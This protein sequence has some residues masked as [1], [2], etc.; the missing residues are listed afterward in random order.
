ARWPGDAQQPVSALD[1]Q[2]E[3]PM[4]YALSGLEGKV[5]VI[6]GAARM[7]SIGRSIAGRLAQ[8]GCDVVLT[9]TR[10]AASSFPDEE[11]AAGWT[12]IDAVVGEVEACGGRAPPPARGPAP[13]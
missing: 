10:R 4:P 12:G 7:R 1:E 3:A 9:G 6:T 2:L 13:P 8:A 5:A 11:R